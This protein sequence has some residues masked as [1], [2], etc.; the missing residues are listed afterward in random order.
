MLKDY[1]G[2]IERDDMPGEYEIKL[3]DTSY[4]KNPSDT[5]IYESEMKK[6]EALTFIGWDKDYENEITVKSIKGA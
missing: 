3:T 5:E 4:R 2:D 6:I 1:E